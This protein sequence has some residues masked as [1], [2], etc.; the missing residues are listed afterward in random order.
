MARSDRQ[1][2]KLLYIKQLLEQESDENHLISA[3]RIIDYLEQHGIRA[4]R[5]SIYSDVMWLQE[6]GMDV[7]CVRGKNGGY[8]LAS[9]EFE[10]PELKLLADA[11]VSSKFLSERK[12]LELIRK[13]GTL[14]SS[15]ESVSLR[16]QLMISGRVKS[17]NE[18]VYYNVDRIHDAI[19]QNRQISFRYYE[20]GMDRQ[21]HY[22]EG[23]YI[24]SPYALCWDEQNYYLIAHT[25][26]HGITH[27]RVDK[28][29][30]IRIT[31]QPRAA[32]E[33]VKKLDLTE[34]GK[35]VF[36]MFNGKTV[37]VT[38]CFESTL[39]GVVI[40]RFG[41]DTILVPQ[42]EAHFTFTAPIT[43]SPLFFGWLCSF[44]DRARVVFPE[45][46]AQE[47]RK[48][49]KQILSSYGE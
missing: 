18:S 45:S 44:G 36:G 4:E 40:D 43:V 21:K 32:D 30:S 34:Y 28:M 16:R 22:R 33:Q 26:R 23:T 3:S 19:A 2:L 37:N 8:F 6:F 1:K 46:V 25:E 31:E 9:R 10:L 35:S 47:H 11:V 27:Y 49:C 24:A 13:L 20:W 38:M 17:M 12:S 39:A 48:L 41:S 5:K 7:C 14:A 15:R 29:A 42:D